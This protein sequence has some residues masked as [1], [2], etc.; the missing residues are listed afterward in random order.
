MSPDF[1]LHGRLAACG[2]MRRHEKTS[3]QPSVCFPR[4]KTRT[5]R[6]TTPAFRAPTM[7]PT[8]RSPIAPCE[9]ASHSTALATTFDMTPSRAVLATT[10]SLISTNTTSLHYFTNSASGPTTKRI[11]CRTRSPRMLRR[12]QHELFVHWYEQAHDKP[13]EILESRECAIRWST[14]SVG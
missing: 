10:A 9:M 1:S 8:R 11:K 5:C 14:H 12:P 2:S 7:P 6:C 4:W 13:R 3:K